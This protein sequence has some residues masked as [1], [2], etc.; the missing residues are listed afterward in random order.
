MNHVVHSFIG[1]L[2]NER[3]PWGNQE[4]CARGVVYSLKSLRINSYNHVPPQAPT[5]TID[6]NTSSRDTAEW[7]AEYALQHPSFA[8]LNLGRFEL[9]PVPSKS[10]RSMADPVGP[11]GLIAESIAGRLRANV[12]VT[13]CLY[14]TKRMES[15]RSGGTRCP[16]ALAEGMG[17]D[18]MI[19]MLGVSHPAVIV[20]DVVTT[21]GHI[22]AARQ[23]LADHGVPLAPFSIVCA[24]A[25]TVSE[26]LPFS[27]KRASLDRLT[28]AAMVWV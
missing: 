9:V 19:E 8:D 26:E 7:F 15:S 17:V 27:H 4:H 1:Y 22:L 23:V 18:D 24:R 2:G 25:L 14:F 12:A 5:F 13:D 28:H 20:D 6:S 10:R 11:A 3:S 21:G 16:D